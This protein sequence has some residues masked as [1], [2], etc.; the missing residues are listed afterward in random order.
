M[1]GDHPHDIEMAVKVGA[2]SA[3]VLTGHGKKHQKELNVHPDYL[4][5]NIFQA[6]VWIQSAL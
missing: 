1:I 6:A 3:Y 5:E 4:T 2:K